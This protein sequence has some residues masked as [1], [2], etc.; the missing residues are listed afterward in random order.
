M[1]VFG[2]GSFWLLTKT[3]PA[4][5]KSAI[6]VWEIYFLGVLIPYAV[7]AFLVFAYGDLMCLK[8][9]LYMEN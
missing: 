5:Q 8:L 2:M 3:I 6:G 4:I 7:G 9:K 1:F